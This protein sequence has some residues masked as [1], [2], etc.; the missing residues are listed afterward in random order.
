VTGGRQPDIRST[1]RRPLLKAL[2]GGS[3]A[4]AAIAAATRSGV[5][6]GRSAGAQKFDGLPRL[7]LTAEDGSS[8]LALEVRLGD[9][10][11][12]RVGPSRWRSA[13]L[14]TSTHS[15]VG[16]T[17]RWDQPEPRVEIRSKRRGGWSA[18]RRVP[19]LD[20]LPDQGDAE[21]AGRSGTQLL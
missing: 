2:A 18:W 20:D 14:P 8:V 7:Q 3:A 6:S 1:R 9:D 21:W 12:P 15:M 5:I 13:H 11:V 19:V 4:V 17:W 10:L 16:F